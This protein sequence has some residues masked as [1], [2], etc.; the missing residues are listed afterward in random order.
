MSKQ[1]LIDQ[2]DDAISRVLAG[3]DVQASAMDASLADLLQIARD[4]RELPSPGFKGR[5]SVD[6]ERQIST[7]MKTVTFPPGFRTVT[8][9]LLPPSADF[10]D[11]LK[12]VFGGVETFRAAASPASFHA[13]VRIGDSMLMIGVGSGRSMPAGLF[14]YVPN[15]DEV[16]KRALDAG[17]VELEPVKNDYGDRFGC[18]QD[19]AG[20]QWVI[21]THLG[22]NYIRENFNT[23]TVGFRASG[24]SRFIEFVKRAFGAQEIQRYEWPGG[25]YANLKIGDSVVSV[26][27]PTN[28]E[29][30]RP[31]RTMVN[32]YVPDADAVYEQ[33]LR[34]GAKS[35]HAPK[36]QPYGVRSG[37]VEDE[38]GNQWFIATPL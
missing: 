12:N 36:D 31:G 11:F 21:A 38:W 33:S 2:L 19:P 32:L 7:S 13:E 23:V 4:L 37:G 24:A 27:E 16:Y 28:R 30:M 29:W 15:V 20:N 1:A 6:L 14:V 5:L 35:I 18:V 9:Y 26:S 34:A 22:P 8:P 3:S 17:C 10:I 25:M